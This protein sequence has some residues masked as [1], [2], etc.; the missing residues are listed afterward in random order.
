MYWQRLSVGDGFD[1]VPDPLDNNFGYAMG[2]AGAL[3][4]YNKASGQLQ[5]I[6][7]IH[8]NEEYLRWNWN[9]GIAID[10]IDKLTIYYGS[11]FLHK[12]SDH[13]RTWE[14]ISPDLTTNDST[15]QNFLETGG[16]TY[17]VT[18]AEF[19]GCIVS[20]APSPLD[21]NVTS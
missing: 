19:H 17:D 12:S 7:P 11:Q 13:G 21:Q 18:G 3:V 4:R 1:V 16:L 15:K 2:Q 8:P 20:I 14:I 6:R 10:P 9:A 5:P